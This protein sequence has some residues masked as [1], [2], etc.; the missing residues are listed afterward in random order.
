M[1]FARVSTLKKAFA[2]TSSVLLLLTPLATTQIKENGPEAK[3]PANP[4]SSSPV[5][6]HTTDTPDLIRETQQ[7]LRDKDYVGL[8]WWVP[9]EFW[10]QAGVKRGQAKD[11]TEEN[12]KALKDYTIV[13]VFAARVSGLGVFTYVA[14]V[15]LQKKVVIRDADNNEYTALSDP[16]PDAKMLVAII[17]PML[18]AALGK[19]GD[20]FEMLF[21]PA[22]NKKGQIIADPT[23]KGIF[24]IVFK[25]PPDLPESIFQWKTP[26]TSISPPKYCP[27]GKE[28]VN[29]NWDYCPWHG[30]SLAERPQH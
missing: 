13:G 3:A 4:N 2:L 29:S 14:P 10:E 6:V 5:L 23:A 24:S 22:R 20:N 8:I 19:A 25:D 28:R 15:E 17:K 18:A 16:G 1:S 21:F 7:G 11:K 9:F 26:L 27:V 12:F 30:V